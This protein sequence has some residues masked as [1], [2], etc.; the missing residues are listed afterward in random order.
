MDKKQHEVLDALVAAY[1]LCA[2]ARPAAGIDLQ[3]AIGRCTVSRQ[4]VYAFLRKPEHCIA[5][6]KALGYTEGVYTPG[7]YFPSGA[8]AF[9]RLGGPCRGQ[10]GRIPPKLRLR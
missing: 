8:G 4:R 6:A 2:G 10:S 3:S 7:F 9:G 5:V 1:R